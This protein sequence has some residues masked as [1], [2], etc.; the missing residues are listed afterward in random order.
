MFGRLVVSLM[1]C[2]CRS[3]SRRARHGVLKVGGAVLDM[4]DFMREYRPVVRLAWLK[5]KQA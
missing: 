4:F 3:G 1:L 2:R 5:G